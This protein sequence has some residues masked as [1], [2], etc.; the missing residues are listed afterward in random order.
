[1]NSDFGC[2]FAGQI[3]QLALPLWLSCDIIRPPK[4]AEQNHWR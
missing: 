2:F 3:P 1:M 4:E